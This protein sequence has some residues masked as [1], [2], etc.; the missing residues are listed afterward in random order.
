MIN[1]PWKWRICHS[2]IRPFRTLYSEDRLEQ[3]ERLL[4]NTLDSIFNMSLAWLDSDWRKLLQSSMYI[5]LTQACL[6][7]ASWPSY[8]ELRCDVARALLGVFINLSLFLYTTL[9]L[10]GIGRIL[11]YSAISTI[12]RQSSLQLGEIFNSRI[13]RDLLLFFNEKQI[14][15]I[16]EHVLA[17]FPEQI[18]TRT[19]DMV[20]YI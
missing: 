3:C 5:A 4:E 1:F 11:Y 9:V 8:V 14:V 20:G 19:D 17:F 12:R 18:H 16:L 6:V 15:Q 10:D 2:V 7:G 13:R